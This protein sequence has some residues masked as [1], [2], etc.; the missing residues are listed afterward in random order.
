MN[1]RGYTFSDFLKFI[2]LIFKKKVEPIRNS[3]SVTPS[4]ELLYFLSLLL[5]L[6]F[7]WLGSTVNF[8]GINVGIFYKVLCIAV[9]VPLL[10]SLNFQYPGTIFLLIIGIPIALFVAFCSNDFSTLLLL[11]L[12]AISGRQFELKKIIRFIFT[13]SLVMFVFTIAL[14]VLGIFTDLVYFQSGRNRHSL[15][16]TYPIASAIFFSL[17]CM[18]GYL[19]AENFNLS[20][21]LLCFLVATVLFILTDTKFFY[22]ATLLA[23]L[24]FYLGNPYKYDGKFFVLLSKSA[25]LIM[26]LFFIAAICLYSAYVPSNHIFG[27]LDSVLNGRLVLGH[28]AI[29]KYGFQPFGQEIEWVTYS[30]ENWWL[31][32]YDYVDSSF[33]KY[34]L[35]YGYVPMIIYALLCSRYAY[36]NFKKKSDSYSSHLFLLIG[37]MALVNPQLIY[38]AYNPTLLMVLA[39]EVK[40]PYFINPLINKIKAKFDK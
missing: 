15:G 14:S 36:I 35:M 23:L 22:L 29:V 19:Q 6:A 34:T 24:L 40:S 37:L 32:G 2:L 31:Y 18:L 27:F 26:P 39:T 4:N 28:N 25:I 20:H 9:V 5:W 17:V 21:V 38:I 10:F 7:F 1:I 16:Y 12:F 30:T 13:L 33:I 8:Q 3:L 11:V